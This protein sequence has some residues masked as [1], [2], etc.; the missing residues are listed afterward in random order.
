MLPAL[1]GVNL[2]L[3]I[4]L[5][6]ACLIAAL[7][8]GGLLPSVKSPV[9]LMFTALTGWLM[10]ATLASQWRGGSVVALIMWA[11]SFACVLV[12]PALISD[13]AQLRKSF[14]VLAFC[15]VPILITTVMLQSQQEGR[16]NTVYGTLSNPND[17]ALHL[18]LL[19]PFAAF[20]MK[21]ESILSWKTIVCA[22]A[23][24]LAAIKIVRTGSR[25]GLLSI[26]VCLII[27]FVIGKLTTKI[28]MLGAAGLIAILAFTFVPTPILLRY[29]TV[30]DGTTLEE[31]MSATER[32]AVESTRARKM[33]FQESVRVMFEHPLFG[34]GPGIFSAALAGEQQKQG[35]L[36]S[37]HEAHNSF[38]Q[39]GSEAGLP[40]F[41]LYLGILIYSF[42]RTVSI[43]RRTRLDPNQK[44]IS[45]MAGT[46]A[47]ALVI[48]GIGATFGTYSYTIHLPVLAGLVQAF[49][50]YLRNQKTGGPAPIA[51]PQP[52]RPAM[53][54]PALTP[55]VPN[56]V[57]NRRLR[58]RRV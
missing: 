15:L 57:R 4:V 58:D 55:Q 26:L 24:V 7:L 8:T 27:L 52:M 56:Y 10:L 11:P 21:R 19:I 40:A 34:V 20:V 18:L 41:F 44:V 28:K 33:L 3:A 50:L 29:T 43:Y 23:V 5:M 25:A 48:F 1:I 13:L 37:W 30:L 2:H 6:G 42:K 45:Q 53:P 17:L 14:Y 16:D 46:L 39:I 49:D 12:L 32:S 51:A 38:T 22:A 36:Q 35:E 31:G 47:M 54:A 9:V